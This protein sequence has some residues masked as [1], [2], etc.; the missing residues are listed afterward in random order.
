MFV[1]T[2][3][4]NDMTP[5]NKRKQLSRLARLMDITGYNNEGL[6]GKPLSY[7][8]FN[9]IKDS[10]TFYE[11]IEAEMNSQT[12]EEYKQLQNELM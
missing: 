1:L 9:K 11:K 4:K 10:I 7:F 5:N 2:K 6:F 8:D 12:Y 3:K